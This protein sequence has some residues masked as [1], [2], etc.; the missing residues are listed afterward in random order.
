MN[1]YFCF[2]QDAETGHQRLGPF[3]KIE[4]TPEGCW[5]KEVD[6]G[7]RMFYHWNH[8]TEIQEE[9]E[10]VDEMKETELQLDLFDAKEDAGEDLPY[11][12]S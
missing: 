10:D 3:E 11:E 7:K 2:H 8:I 5:F 6:S 9:P 1:L 4:M 12:H